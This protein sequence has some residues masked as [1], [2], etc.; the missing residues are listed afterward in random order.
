MVIAKCAMSYPCVVI[1]VATQAEDGFIAWF[2]LDDSDRLSPITIADSLESICKH[3]IS[4]AED[5]EIPWYDM[6]G[7]AEAKND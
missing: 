1:D 4:F 3:A 6:T 2:C 7:K 5:L